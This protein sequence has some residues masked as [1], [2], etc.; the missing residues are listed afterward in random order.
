M[1]VLLFLLLIKFLIVFEELATILIPKLFRFFSMMFLIELLG[2]MIDLYNLLLFV[3][4]AE[5]SS[6]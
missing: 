4:L 2:K 5:I 3:R 1:W 6:N